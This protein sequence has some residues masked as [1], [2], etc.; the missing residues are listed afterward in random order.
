MLLCGFF[1]WCRCKNESRV[2]FDADTSVQTKTPL[3]CKECILMQEEAFCFR[4]T[5]VVTHSTLLCP[6]CEAS[7]S[8]ASTLVYF[9][10]C[11]RMMMSEGQEP[12]MTSVLFWLS[13][14]E[15]ML[16]DGTNRNFDLREY[17][18]M[19]ILSSITNCYDEN[20]KLTKEH[21]ACLNYYHYS[22]SKVFASQMCM[23]IMD[24]LIPTFDEKKFKTA[25]SCIV[26]RSFHWTDIDIQKPR[27][28]Y[29]E[30]TARVVSDALVAHLPIVL[31]SFITSFD[32]VCICVC[33]KNKKS[34]H[35]FSCCT[36]PCHNHLACSCCFENGRCLQCIHY[37]DVCK[38][39]PSSNNSCSQCGASCCKTCVKIC[40]NCNYS[41]CTAH[42]RKCLGCETQLCKTCSKKACHQCHETGRCLDCNPIAKCSSCNR[43]SC[44][45]HMIQ[46]SS[47]MV[48]KDMHCI[49]KCKNCNPQTICMECKSET[50]F[51]F[52]LSCNHATST[53]LCHS[54]PNKTCNK[55]SQKCRLCKQRSCKVCRRYIAQ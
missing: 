15:G 53:S 54:C 51:K 40:K 30:Q 6:V 44:T 18:L 46:C 20:R 5:N 7:M 25:A 52:A 28:E 12:D 38:Q 36:I 17:C 31:V 37:C 1:T 35:V 22:T 49:N 3:V 16:N 50:F 24:T 10:T 4:C 42:A 34:K 45:E 27:P 19:Q 13:M 26:C 9:D 11:K 33:S 55:C 47:C 48:L 23:D 8:F 32:S 2:L 43:T 39:N 21:Y 41:M 14:L 29:L